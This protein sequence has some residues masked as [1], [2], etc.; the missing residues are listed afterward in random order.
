MKI[1]AQG[2]GALQCHVYYSTDGFVTRKTIFSTSAALSGTWNEINNEDVV[3]VEEGEQLLI[4]VYPWSGQVDNGRWIC[5]SDV[6]V[7]GQ[8]KDAAGV[9]ITGT[10]SYALDKGGLTQGDDVVLIDNGFQSE[11]SGN[12]SAEFLAI[13]IFKPSVGTNKTMPSPRFE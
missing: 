8:S 3:K 9:N 12:E 11:T 10:I 7:K 2:G 1:K 4:R 5:I 13:L 6:A